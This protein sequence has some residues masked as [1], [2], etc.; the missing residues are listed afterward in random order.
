M[1]SIFR[2]LHGVDSG[3][4]GTMARG[5]AMK[6]SSRLAEIIKGLQEGTLSPAEAVVGLTWVWLGTTEIEGV[7]IYDEKYKNLGQIPSLSSTSE[8]PEEGPDE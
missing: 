6:L 4:G 2:L 5:C 8:D 3:Y 7:L 1:V